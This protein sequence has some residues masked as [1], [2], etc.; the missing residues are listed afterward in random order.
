MTLIPFPAP[1]PGER[2][3]YVVG[4][5]R[6]QSAPVLYFPLP[7]PAIAFPQPRGAA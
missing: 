5:V 7:K 3:P 2:I 1:K 6:G 4:R